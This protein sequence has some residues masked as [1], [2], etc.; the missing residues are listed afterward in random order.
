MGYTPNYYDIVLNMLYSIYNSVHSN[1]IMWNYLMW[2][3]IIIV[4]GII[5][6]AIY[7]KKTYDLFMF[8]LWAVFFTVEFMILDI[9]RYMLDK[10]NEYSKYLIAGLCFILLINAV[11]LLF[12][13]DKFQKQNND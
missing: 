12:I 2:V 10:L 11:I 1:I 6:Y 8:L 9:F 3:C 13:I 4:I 7:T 5:G